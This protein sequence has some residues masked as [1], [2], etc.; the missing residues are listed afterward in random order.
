[1]PDMHDTDLASRVEKLEEVVAK[2][3]D[4]VAQIL[5]LLTNGPS[6]SFQSQS[7]HARIDA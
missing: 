7:V 6:P 5:S 4:Y 1:M 3:K 2:L